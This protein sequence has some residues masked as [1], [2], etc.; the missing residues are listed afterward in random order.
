MQLLKILNQII[1][2]Q[3]VPNQIK[4]LFFNGVLSLICYLRL[5]QIHRAK[6][7]EK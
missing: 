3:N 5:L 2:L 1:F 4:I 6:S 7:T